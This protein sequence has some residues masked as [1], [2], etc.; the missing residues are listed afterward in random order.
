VATLTST[1]SIYRKLIYWVVG[2][3]VLS[4]V[5]LILIRVG[6]TIKN[7]IAPA[8]PS[9]AT[10]AFGLLPKL[11]YSEGYEPLNDTRFLV[12]TISGGLP[13]LGD[14]AKVFVTLDAVEK[15]GVL[16]KAIE[17]A[18]QAGFAETP[19]ETSNRVAR[20]VDPKD[21]TRIL[22]IETVSGSISVGSGY[23]RNP[24]IIVSRPESR[25]KP[26]QMVVNLFNQLNLPLEIFPKDTISQE[27]FKIENG[28]LERA[29]S[30]S[31]TN[32]VKVIFN[33]AD[34]DD[35]PIINSDSENP[36][37]W[38][39]ANDEIVVSAQFIS[40]D[41]Q[42]HRFSTYPL[43]SPDIAVEDLRKGNGALNK[44]P[45]SNT[46]PIRNVRLAYLETE[47]NQGFLQPVYLFESDDG[48]TAYTH[49][50]ADIFI[51]KD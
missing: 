23:L 14:K 34:I 39:L 16:E 40:S 28:I 1:I 13:S 7:L 10:I 50:V 31:T 6:G 37:V 5:V 2:A 26:Q 12:E 3:I 22:T 30:L 38:G 41:I 29:L 9:P 19:I 35:L 33:K 32:L 25:E 45:D 43:K 4:I 49:A 36:L 11:D 17:G 51:A 8:P 46:F 18:R 21:A 48:L 47:K 15:F 42:K 20:F 44:K 24:V 27:N